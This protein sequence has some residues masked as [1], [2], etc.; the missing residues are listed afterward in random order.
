VPLDTPVDS[1]EVHG[2]VI[3]RVRIHVWFRGYTTPMLKEGTRGRNWLFASVSAAQRNVCIW[4]PSGAGWTAL[5]ID[6]VAIPGGP[7]EPIVL[8]FGGLRNSL[9]FAG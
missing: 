1:G 2:L 9:S 7:F 4:E 6:F 3:K 8:A 5:E